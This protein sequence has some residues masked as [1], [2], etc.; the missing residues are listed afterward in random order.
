MENL[1]D[2][3]EIIFENTKSYIENNHS[4]AKLRLKRDKKM[5]GYIDI[6]AGKKGKDAHFHIG[7]GF[8]GN[9]I[10]RE[11]R[12]RINKIHKT[13]NSNLHGKIFDEQIILKNSPGSYTFRIVTDLH[14]PTKKAI[15]KK[16]EF[17]EN[18]TKENHS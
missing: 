2:P 17:I 10:F 15:L 8:N 14:E 16:F 18:S 12:D 13:V 6:V 5:G 4:W 1:V 7:F 9:E 3:K 11:D